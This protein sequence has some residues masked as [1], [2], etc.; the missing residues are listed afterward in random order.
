MKATAAA[1]AVLLLGGCALATPRPVYR[2]GVVNGG[3]RI[4]VVGV[5]PLVANRYSADVLAGQLAFA[6]T[7]RGRNAVSLSTFAESEDAAGRPLPEDVRLKLQAGVVGPDTASWLQM[8]QVKGVI[9]LE[10]QIYDQVWSSQG[11]RT[12]VAMMARGHD[13][14]VGEDLWRAF[15]T[16]EVDDEAG[17]GFQ[18]ASEA[19]VA[20]LARA[21]S[22]ESEPFTG[23]PKIPDQ[24]IKIPAVQIRW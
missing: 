23:L 2:A 7:Q 5:E 22:G 15:V 21:I 16:P 8:V 9:F 4:L 24:E 13:L 14:F 18:I 6:L 11:K 17:R 3:Q 10:T 20:G 12:R 19:A 1:F